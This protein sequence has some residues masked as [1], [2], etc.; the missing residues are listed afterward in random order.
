M[1]VSYNKE[2][3]DYIANEMVVNHSYIEK[4]YF[5]VKVIEKLADFNCEN[6][7]I[8]FSGGT[9]LSKGYGLIQRFSE[10][11]D[12]EVDDA[13]GLTQ[14]QRRNI[15]HAFIDVISQIADIE[16]VENYAENGG[17]K[18]TLSIKYPHIYP[19]PGNLRDNLKVE[20]FFEPLKLTT[21]ERIINSFIADFSNENKENAK[22]LC[23]HPFNILADKFNALTW[24][25]YNG[26]DNFDYTNMRHLHDLYAIN[27]RFDDPEEFKKRVLENFEKKDKQR[28]HDKEFLDLLQE[29]N[30]R[31]LM[32]EVY[33]K[34]YEKFVDSMSYAPDEQ[35][36][37][38]EDAL[39]C[40]QK[41]SKLFL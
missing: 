14:G 41:L 10:D 7:Q 38:Y 24:R 40:Y 17:R 39:G 35:R 11:L 5:A 36:I 37:S 6:H 21:Q 15:R 9:S 27:Q 23:N 33:K 34:G 18:Q 32:D 28:V 31:L 8:I 4:D 22:I 25:V 3:V 16:I 26:Q 2:I 12:F 29:T 1:N 19:I 13:Q 30:K 20:L